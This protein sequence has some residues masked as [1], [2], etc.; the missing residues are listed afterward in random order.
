MKTAAPKDI[1]RQAN[2]KPRRIYLNARCGKRRRIAKSRKHTRSNNTKRRE[3]KISAGEA[4]T[5]RLQHHEHSRK[6]KHS[7]PVQRARHRKL[8]GT[9][10]VRFEE[11]SDW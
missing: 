9:G 4:A 3:A 8:Q 2:P 5:G 7:P 1:N 11:M 10:R 6:L